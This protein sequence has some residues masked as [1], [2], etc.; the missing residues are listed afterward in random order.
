MTDVRLVKAL[1]GNK[2]LIMIRRGDAIKFIDIK[3]II[4]IIV[5]FLYFL[6]SSITY[7]DIFIFLSILALS[8]EIK[9]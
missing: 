2:R 1:F 9:V 5:T 7:H 6:N 4:K 8:L 3:Q